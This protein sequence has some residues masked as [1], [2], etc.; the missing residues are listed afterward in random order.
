MADE[1]KPEQTNSELNLNQTDSNQNVSS[2]LPSNLQADIGLAVTALVLGLASLA[3]AI[4]ALG[5]VPG[6][7]GLIIAISHLRKKRV[8]RAMA[9]WGLVLSSI[10]FLVGAGFGVIYGIQV[11]NTCSM[12]SDMQSDTSDYIEQ[13]L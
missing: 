4:F 1:Y 3:T 9:I 10:G 2:M 13:V 6:I 5:A 8:F 7:I 12:Y 11:Y